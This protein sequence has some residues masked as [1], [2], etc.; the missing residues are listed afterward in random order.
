VQFV[1]RGISPFFENHTNVDLAPP[2]DAA[3]ANREKVVKRDIEIGR[4]NSQF[5]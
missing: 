5:V 3:F 2:S 1:K 4:K